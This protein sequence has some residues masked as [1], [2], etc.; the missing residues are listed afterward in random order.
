MAKKD[1]GS[2]TETSSRSDSSIPRKQRQPAKS[3]PSPSPTRPIAFRLAA[4]PGCQIFV[5]GTFNNWNPT[6][7]QLKEEDGEEGIFSTVLSL[8]LGRYEYKL[9]V[10]NT[11]HIDPNCPDWVP[12]NFGSL[13]SVLVV[14]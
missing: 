14:E 6:Q 11:W 2:I 13:N 4:E 12:N 10:N 5:A 9:I 1:T 3:T 8:P 7:Y